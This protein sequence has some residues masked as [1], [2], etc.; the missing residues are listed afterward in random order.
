MNTKRSQ[1]SILRL[2]QINTKSGHLNIWEWD[3]LRFSSITSK[4]GSNGK[5]RMRRRRAIV[6]VMSPARVAKY[7]DDRGKRG[8]DLC[9]LW[10]NAARDRCENGPRSNTGADGNETQC[11]NL[12]VIKII[13]S[14]TAIFTVENDRLSLYEAVSVFLRDWIRNLISISIIRAGQLHVMM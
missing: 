4:R 8:L 13:A 2:L 3:L 1:G 12:C 10:G 11:R 7:V 14:L 9:F 5:Q 6:D